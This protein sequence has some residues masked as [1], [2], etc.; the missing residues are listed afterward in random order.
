MKIVII[1]NALTPH[2]LPLCDALAE[3]ID[4]F[5]F[6]EAENI[7]KTALPLGWR[8]TRKRD[9]VVPYD[10]LMTHRAEVEK[11]ILSADAVIMGGDRTEFVKNRL[12]KG[13]LT[14]EYSER[15]YK[16]IRERLKIP[17]HCFK[18]RKWR[19][20]PNL[21]LLCAS[22]FA[23]SDYQKIGC[24]KNKAFK[25]GY[26][27]WVSDDV[28]DTKRSQNV[29]KMLYASRFIDWKHP[30]LA[31]LLAKE[32]K[33][34]GYE[35]ELNMYG[36][37]PEYAKIT[38]L[39]SSL[40]LN[41]EVRMYGSVPNAEILSQMRQHDAFIFTSDSNEG[42]GAVAN[43]AMGNGS[44]LVAASDIGSVPYLLAD[45]I[46]GCIF[47]E[48]D[49]DSLTS[50]VEWLIN[51]PHKRKKLALRGFET[52]HTIWSAETAANNLLT[53]IGDLQDCRP[54]SITEGPCSPT[55]LLYNNWFKPFYQ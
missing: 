44:V 48:N 35:F 21:Y 26:F 55:D 11:L 30:E 37:G 24:F 42:W 45:R 29:F 39:I 47:K 4:E 15:I 41:K 3:R 12:D 27:P 46:N 18:F 14:F 31:V 53:L 22:A 7:D 19:R 6:I 32:L 51:N 36:D 2:Q 8:E 17:Y 5:K 28:I 25:W 20:Y 9:Y 1:S 49:I 52:I 54:V 16:N 43:E 50:Q 33:Q 13:L 40:N 38:N 23:Y 10:Y 34:K